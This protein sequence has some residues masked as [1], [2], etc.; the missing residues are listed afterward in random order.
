MNQATVRIPTPLRK[1]TD[2]ASEVAVRGDTVWEALTSLIESHAGL[3]DKLFGD[4]GELRS[5][6]NIF[7]GAENVRSRGGVDT[8]V[9]DGEVLSILPA[10]AGGAR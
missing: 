10:V 6:V 1:F 8:P 9:R 3:A 2:G 7:V 5:F 4:D